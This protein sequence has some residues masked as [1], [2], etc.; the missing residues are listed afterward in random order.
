M[1]D[2]ALATTTAKT[3]YQSGAVVGDKALCLDFVLDVVH[4]CFFSLLFY[5]LA[6]QFLRLVCSVVCMYYSTRRSQLQ[7]VP[8]NPE[9]QRLRRQALHPIQLQPTTPDPPTQPMAE[10]QQ[11]FGQYGT[12]VSQEFQ[13][14][15][16][17]PISAAPYQIH[18]QFTRMVKE[19]PFC[20]LKNEC[21]LQHLEAFSDICG[22][23]P[24]CPN[25]PDYVRMHLFHLSLI[26]DA[27]DWYKWI[28]PNS[29][30]T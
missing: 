11:L 5:I 23:I 16:V 12:P 14:G 15:V 21:P 28:K 17:L 26:G 8:Y 4:F 20:G 10:D 7:L 9:I 29:I 6:C 30:T 3:R 25:S 22:L 1:F 13:G 24:P 27:K 18:R 19:T 2:S